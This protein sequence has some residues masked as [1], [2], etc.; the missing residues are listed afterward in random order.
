MS[1]A[2]QTKQKIADALLEVHLAPLAQPKAFT[3]V[4]LLDGKNSQ[5]IHPN[6]G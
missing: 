5:Q 1:F 2:L 3:P 6:G 4:R